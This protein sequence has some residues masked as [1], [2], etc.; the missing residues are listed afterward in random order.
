MVAHMKDTVGLVHQMPFVCDRPGLPS[1]LEQVGCHTS[2]SMMR[3]E[4]HGRSSVIMLKGK[5]VVTTPLFPGGRIKKVQNVAIASFLDPGVRIWLSPNFCSGPHHYV[6]MNLALRRRPKGN[7]PTSDM[8]GYQM[9]DHIT[10]KFAVAESERS[11][12]GRRA[13][14]LLPPPYTMYRISE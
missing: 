8:K 12:C 5:Y 6:C 3:I 14:F 11:R 10:K 4:G 2:M 13:N 1:T 9:R 7:R